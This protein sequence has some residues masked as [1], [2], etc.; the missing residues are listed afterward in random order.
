MSEIKTLNG[1]GDK[2][3]KTLEDAGFANI[4]DLGTTSVK[5]LER[6]SDLSE[7]RADNVIQAAM[8][9][10][11][12]G[13]KDGQK[14]KENQKRIKHITTGSDELDKMTGGGI[15]TQMIT[16]VYGKNSTGKSQLAL[17]LAIN[18]QKPEDE[19]GLGKS[20]IFIDTEKTYM[21]ERI[22]QL[23][24]AQDLDSSDALDNIY[25]GQAHSSDHQLMLGEQT[26]QICADEDIG[27][28]VVD[29]IIAHFRVEF[30]GRDSLTE[31]QEK[32]NNHLHTL[33]RVAENYNCAV[34]I[35]NQVYS[36]PGKMFGDPTK[37]IGGNVLAHKSSLRIYLQS[38]G[39]KPESQEWKARLTDSPHLPQQE[40]PFVIDE[41]G[42]RDE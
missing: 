3:A 9:K 42:I 12:K 31:R 18:V 23:A 21:T 20:C 5:E 15:P 39:Q 6:K 10:M 34:F 2:T 25:V 11:N 30:T 16:E 36:D 33:A 4:V 41:N 40:V 17:Q 32:L 8:D 38:T 24:E 13:F 26:Q 1:V 27:L 7:K 14:V 19:G 35:T 28:I 22:E 29:S 37:P